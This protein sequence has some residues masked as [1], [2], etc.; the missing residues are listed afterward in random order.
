MKN[1][2]LVLVFLCGFF[3]ATSSVQAQT[4]N[5]FGIKAGF[6][7]SYNGSYFRDAQ[8]I[9]GDPLD[10]MGYHVGLF[11][12]YHLGPVFVKPEIYFTNFVTNV[13]E[14][15][16]ENRL[17]TRRFDLPFLVGVNLIGRTLSVFGGPSGH[18]FLRDDITGDGGAFNAGFQVGAGLNF[19]RLGLDLRFERILDAQQVSFSDAV[20]FATTDFRFQQLELGISLLF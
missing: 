2:L 6:N 17:I 5:G 1:V 13:V 10:N 18:L 14:S 3:C 8:L 4:S 16:V 7:Y 20:D 11:G 15:G 9:F 19:G 12:K